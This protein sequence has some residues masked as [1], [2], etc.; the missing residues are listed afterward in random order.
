MTVQVIPDET[1]KKLARE[2]LAIQS[3]RRDSSGST[4]EVAERG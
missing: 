2:A 1:L 3:A 4:T